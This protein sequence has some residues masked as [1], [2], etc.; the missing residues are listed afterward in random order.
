MVLLAF[1][2]AHAQMNMAAMPGQAGPANPMPNYMPLIMEN[3]EEVM[4]T[5]E[6]TEQLKQWSEIALP[7]VKAWLNELE[8]VNLKIKNAALAK[9]S[10]DDLLVLEQTAE[11]LRIKIINSKVDCRDN[12]QKI[13]NKKQWQQVLG[14]YNMSQVSTAKEEIYSPMPALGMTLMAHTND[15]SLDSEQ[16]K[17]IS[18]MPNHNMPTMQALEKE[19]SELYSLLTLASLENKSKAEI[20]DLEHKAEANRIELIKAQAD[21]RDQII[22]NLNSEQWQKL[23]EYFNTPMAMNMP[24][25]MDH[26]QHDMAAMAGEA[27]NFVKL[28]DNMLWLEPIVSNN[29]LYLGL[30]FEN[31]LMGQKE[32]RVT[33]PNKQTSIYFVNSDNLL[34]LGQIQSG[35][36]QF[37]GLN[38]EL[39]FKIS[40]YHKKTSKADVY[41]ILAPS[42]SLSGRGKSEMFVYAFNNDLIHDDI[43]FKYDMPGMEHSTDNNEI[44]LEHVHYN[45]P[46]LETMANQ[47]PI[48]FAMVGNWQINLTI[49]SQASEAISFNIEMLDE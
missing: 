37:S 30:N 14:L 44:M 16:A 1:G 18:Q 47:S 28:A 6:Q 23:L 10:I 38:N 45:Y 15:L 33:R 4:L 9:A 43:N 13:L 17:A 36:W 48:S 34:E 2:L 19:I 20:L 32:F 24:M 5:T 29:K 35:I 46:N 12:A 8:E 7:K 31:M 26:S 49:N 39:S 41:L 22:A 42:P 25:N 11:D 40:V 27:Q 3:A 21:C